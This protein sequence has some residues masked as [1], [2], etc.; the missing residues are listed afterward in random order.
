MPVPKLS[1]PSYEFVMV[2]VPLTV[3]LRMP[4]TSRVNSPAVMLAPSSMVKVRLPP[5]T[6]LITSITPFAEEMLSELVVPN[7]RV[8][9]VKLV[10]VIVE[11]P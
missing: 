2:N 3:K 11:L 5:S 8:P 7:F 10:E 6:L 4:V 1:S 9:I